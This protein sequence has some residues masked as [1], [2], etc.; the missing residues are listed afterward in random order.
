MATLIFLRGLCGYVWDSILTLSNL[1][2][3]SLEENGDIAKSLE[4]VTK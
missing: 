3:Q 4:V 2:V 1:R